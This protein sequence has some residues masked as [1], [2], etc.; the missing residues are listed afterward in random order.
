MNTSEVAAVGRHHRLILSHLPCP[1]PRTPFQLPSPCTAAWPCPAD[2]QTKDPMAWGCQKPRLHPVI[3]GLSHQQPFWPDCWSAWWCSRPQPSWPFFIPSPTSLHTSAFPQAVTAKQSPSLPRT[4]ANRHPR[5]GHVV[6]A[7]P[8]CENPA[9][10]VGSGQCLR[11]LPSRAGSNNRPL[12]TD[13]VELLKTEELTAVPHHEGQPAKIPISPSQP[14][15]PFREEA[16][17]V[18]QVHSCCGHEPWGFLL[19]LPRH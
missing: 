6:V 5:S 13:V 15:E 18:H 17:G 9:C 10:T 14:G 11:K 16:C 2:P 7:S 4:P 12:S 1:Q 8:A 19:L 3:R